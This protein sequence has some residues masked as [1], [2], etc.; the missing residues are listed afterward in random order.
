MTEGL[1]KQNIW[2]VGASFG[3]GRALARDLLEADNMLFVTARSESS[4]RDLHSAYPN[5]VKLIPGDITDAEQLKTIERALASHTDVLDMVILCAGTC[6]YDDGPV[7]DT[8]MYR[9]VFDLNFFATV[10]CVRIALP[11]LERAAG[12][13]IALS[14]LAVTAPFPRA[15]AYG[16]SK[17]ALE[18]CMKSLKID[19]KG[20]GVDF[21]LV[22]PGFVDTPLTQKNDFSMPLLMSPDEASKA[23]IKGLVSKKSMISFPWQLRLSLNLAAIFENFWAKLAASRLSRA[24]D[25]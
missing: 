22:R 8:D 19:L 7:L 14:S 17:A 10:D 25:I 13:V 24:K 21:A 23:I 5:K 6:E 16:A 18:Y 11:M 3:I 20:R 4:L 1:S 2:L 9:R 15:E 12:R